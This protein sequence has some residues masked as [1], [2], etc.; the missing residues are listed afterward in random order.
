[1]SIRGHTGEI[2]HVK[3]LGQHCSRQTVYDCE[4][5]MLS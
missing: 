3:P 4:Y 1:M 2:E 5:E